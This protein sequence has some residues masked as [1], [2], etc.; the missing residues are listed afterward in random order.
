MGLVTAAA[1]PILRSSQP[2]QE[3]L[4]GTTSIDPDDHL[5][6]RL[7]GGERELPEFIQQRAIR[8]S[9]QQWETN[10]LNHG[11]IETI[12]DHVV[13]GGFRFEADDAEVQK[14]LE[15]HWNDQRNRWDLK[16][17]DRVRELSLFGEQLYA[18]FVNEADGNVRIASIDPARVRDVWTNPEDPDDVVAVV[19]NPRGLAGGSG[20][21]RVYRVIHQDENPESDSL[22]YLV[23]AVPGDT[24]NYPGQKTEHEYTGS[25]FWFTVNKL[26]GARRGRPDLLSAIDWLDGYDQI[27]FNFL[28]RTL[29]MNAFV[30]DVS[31][32][33]ATNAQIDAWR[34]ANG[35]PPKPGTVSV[36]NAS[37]KWEAVSPQIIRG[38]QSVQEKAVKS[39]IL[40]APGL[41]PH[42]FGDQDANRATAVEMGSPSIKRLQSRQLYVKFMIEH[43]LQFQVDQAVLKGRLPKPAENT[44]HEFKV[45]VPE[46]SPRDLT[47]ASTSLVS[48]VNALLGAISANLIDEEEARR[49]FSLVASQVGTEIDI[50]AMVKRIEAKAAT[51]LQDVEPTVLAEAL[52]RVE[53]ALREKVA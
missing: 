27:L 9:W 44:R 36:H 19:T 50:D 43:I 6:R 24:F 11:I 29:M 10:P 52:R 47:T 12:K 13:G 25:C 1:E 3:Q 8:L 31:L 22:G 35:K 30:W 33:G 32:D 23:G 28:D 40:S 48:I 53:D 20:A 37:E 7:S 46:M 5:Y 4:L 17:H 39:Q 16:Q 41:P 18:V 26:T 51:E 2:L 34:K 14:V 38:E 42:W 45:L 15:K 49:I 21:D